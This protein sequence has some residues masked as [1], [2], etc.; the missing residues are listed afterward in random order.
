MN[1]GNQ[2][3]EVGSQGKEVFFEKFGKLKGCV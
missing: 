3:S 2:R 1:D